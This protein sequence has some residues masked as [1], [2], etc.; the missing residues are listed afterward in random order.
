M[1]TDRCSKRV[2]YHQDLDLRVI[3]RAF[4]R[5]ISTPAIVSAHF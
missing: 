5:G 4:A 2:E 3:V 1:D